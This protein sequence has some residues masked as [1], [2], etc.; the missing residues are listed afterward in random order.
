MAEPMCVTVED[1]IATLTIRGAATRNALSVEV[2]D[3]LLDALA[4]LKANPNA[5]VVIITGEGDKVFSS[6]G[7]LREMPVGSAL[8]MHAGHARFM[9][10]FRAL[11][12]LGKPT[13]ARVA[14]HA[15][16]GG[17]GLIL[18]CD[19][20]IAA[21]DVYVGLPEIQVGLFPMM[22]MALLFRHVGRKH[23]MEMILSGRR[24]GADEAVH[25]GMLNRAVP[26]AALDEAVS[27]LALRVG[28]YSPAILALGRNA[29]HQMEDMDLWTALDYLRGQLTLNTLTEDAA[30]GTQAFLEKRQ[31]Q[32]KGR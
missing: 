22:V 12:T 11:S 18:A 20:A 25:M 6:G 8:E 10:L 28:G 17:L 23:G 1:G 19:M 2:L 31:P 7:D 30:E 5:R 4:S 32:W 29:F 3:A 16:A 9:D 24:V 27:E 14:G 13:I 15:L 21:D 26:R